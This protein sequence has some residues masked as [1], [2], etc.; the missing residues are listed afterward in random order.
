MDGSTAASVAP[1]G[2]TKARRQ[3]RPDPVTGAA[4]GPAPRR[5]QASWPAGSRAWTIPVSDATTRSGPSGRRERRAAPGDTKVQSAPPRDASNVETEGPVATNRRPPGGRERALRASASGGRRPGPDHRPAPD[6]ARLDGA[7]AQERDG[8]VVGRALEGAGRAPEDGAA[9]CVERE[10]PLPAAGDED[11][12][13]EEEPFPG[14]R[15]DVGGGDAPE[16]DPAEAA[17][18]QGTA[19][20]ALLPAGPDPSPGREEAVTLAGLQDVGEG[21]GRRGLQIGEHGVP[22]LAW[23]A[24]PDDGAEVGDPLEDGLGEFQGAA[25]D[26]DGPPDRDR[27]VGH[28]HPGGGVAAGAGQ[29]EGDRS[30][31]RRGEPGRRGAE[32]PEGQVGRAGDGQ[33]LVPR[34]SAE[35]DASPDEEGIQIGSR[36]APGGQ[37]PRLVVDLEAAGRVPPAAVGPQGAGR[38]D[39]DGPRGGQRGRP[40]CGAQEAAKL[41]EGPGR[42]GDLR[43]A[44]AEGGRGLPRRLGE[45][46]KVHLHVVGEQPGGPGEGGDREQ[47][48]PSAAVQEELDRPVLEGDRGVL[49]SRGQPVDGP[50]HPEHA[51]GDGPLGPPGGDVH[52]FDLDGHDVHDGPDGGP[53]GLRGPGPQAGPDLGVRGP[54]QADPDANHPPQPS[55]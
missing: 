13:P 48:D 27:A 47:R 21:D 12:A 26:R 53:P 35:G 49:L 30:C 10:R 32:V 36:S 1:V 28:G 7:P 22:G 43:H 40:C 3:E 38:W 45:P 41:G 17:R 9:P 23:S 5:R 34:G 14:R 50:E 2:V 8:A 20:R 15:P 19:G 44:G 11:V 4:S 46:G 55:T 54:S 24:A 33:E 6:V 29:V 37:S 51:L 16:R 25:P 18:S 52:P 39:G 31:R 42:G